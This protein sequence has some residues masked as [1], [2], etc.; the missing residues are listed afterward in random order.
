MLFQPVTHNMQPQEQ[1]DNGCR[2]SLLE[3]I[4]VSQAI[5]GG[6]KKNLRWIKRFL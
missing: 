5:F 3:G 1:D 2:G 4:R 6:L